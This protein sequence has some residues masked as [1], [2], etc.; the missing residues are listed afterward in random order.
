MHQNELWQVYKENGQAVPGE[1]ITPEQ[2]EANDLHIVGCSITWIYR[3]RE[4]RLEILWQKRAKQIDRF[5]GFWD[6]SAGGHIN[7]GET[8]VE[9]AVREAYEEIGAKISEDDLK[10]G[11][12]SNWKPSRFWWVYFVDYSERED[13]FD[14]TDGEVDEVKWVKFEDFER[15]W[16]ENAKP[17][18]AQDEMSYR[19]TM[20]WF[21]VHGYLQDNG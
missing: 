15:F 12:V 19:E 4:G 13:D 16:R 20:K 2:A 5:G 18:L 7:L 8:P 10:F 6:F 14:F 1:G 9:G 11:F 3:V 17:P 21:E